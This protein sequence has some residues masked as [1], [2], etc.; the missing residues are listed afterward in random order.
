MTIGLARWRATI[1]RLEM[2]P[3]RLWRWVAEERVI[4]DS[5]E[6]GSSGWQAM[7]CASRLWK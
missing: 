7:R 2:L 1:E 3:R 6:W 4:R 5:E